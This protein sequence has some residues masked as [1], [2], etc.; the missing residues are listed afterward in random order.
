M[1][2]PVSWFFEVGL[3]KQK[4]VEL[5]GNTRILLTVNEHFLGVLAEVFELQFIVFKPI[6][7]SFKRE[8][9]M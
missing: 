8:G 4:L 6:A 3:I 5:L 2:E 7:K 1:F 9:A